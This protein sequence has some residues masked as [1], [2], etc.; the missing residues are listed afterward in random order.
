M[1][2]LLYAFPFL[3]PPAQ[4]E[5]AARRQFDAKVLQA[6]RNYV[7]AINAARTD[8]ISTLQRL[9]KAALRRKD[10]KA[11]ASLQKAMDEAKAGG[12]HQFPAHQLAGTKW[13]WISGSTIV[14]GDG[15][16]AVG[17]RKEARVPFEVLSSNAIGN[18]AFEGHKPRESVFIFDP[19]LTYYLNV[20]YQRGELRTGKRVQN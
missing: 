20:N 16:W 4:S 9:Q 6:Q 11:V 8:Y 14:F 3:F 18:K 2:K 1:H 5:I 17:G 13:T 7:K 15:W 10:A 12:V 19:T